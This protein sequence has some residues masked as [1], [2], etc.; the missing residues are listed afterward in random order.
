MVDSSLVGVLANH[1]LKPLAQV[2]IDIDG[3]QG[4]NAVVGAFGRL[5]GSG[6]LFLGGF[7]LEPSFLQDLDL[8]DEN[9]FDA[10]GLGEERLNQNVLRPELVVD[11]LLLHKRVVDDPGVWPAR[12]AG[13][14]G[15]GT[16]PLAGRHPKGGRF[17]VPLF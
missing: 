5:D 8:G 6:R 1:L 14:Q 13:S 16:E 15:R 2:A 7:G 12:G 4:V 11:D 3:I 9:V 10:L 17:S